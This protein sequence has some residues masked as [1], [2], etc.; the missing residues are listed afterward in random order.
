MQEYSLAK[1]NYFQ[2]QEIHSSNI[3]VQPKAL[4][5]MIQGEFEKK[6]IIPDCGMT[7]PIIKIDHLP[8]HLHSRLKDIFENYRDLFSRS[9]HHLGRFRGFQ[10][11]THI[12]FSSKVNCKQ[13]QRN[14]VLPPS[15]KQDV[16]KYKASGLFANSTGKRITSAVT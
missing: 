13:P 7:N 11:E 2:A 4:D 16:L 1:T 12:D 10:A 5:D 14:R 6:S 8:K 9:K 3:S 15:C